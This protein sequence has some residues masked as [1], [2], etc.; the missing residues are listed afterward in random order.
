M[1]IKRPKRE[2]YASEP[3]YL[4]ACLRYLDARYPGREGQRKRVAAWQRWTVEHDADALRRRI[5]ELFELD[6]W[7]DDEADEFDRLARAWKA[8]LSDE[9]TTPDH[10]ERNES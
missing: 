1:A 3:D 7:T 9:Q 2:R 5:W 8:R 4:L 10:I 6:P